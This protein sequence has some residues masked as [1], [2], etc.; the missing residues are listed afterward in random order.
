[1]AFRRRAIAHGLVAATY[2]EDLHV[3]CGREITTTGDGF[4]V[5]FDD[6]TRAVRCGVAMTRS[7]QRAGLAIRVGIHSGEVDIE[8][9]N[10]RGV[11]V[12]AAARVMSFATAS[13]V[14]VSWT[15]KD[16]LEGSG[17]TIEDAA[18][19]EL[20]GLD[21]ERRLFRLVPPAT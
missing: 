15:T 8:G 10:A 20:K 2:R 16:L 1:M 14:L 19:H 11:A 13:E 17:L 6:P 21:G 3:F 9:S 12:H 7:V 4:L 18:T 5:V